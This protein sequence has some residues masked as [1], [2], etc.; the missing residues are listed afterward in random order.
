MNL[1]NLN[2]LPITDAHNGFFACCGSTSWAEGMTTAR[3]FSSTKHLIETA[4]RLWYKECTE[5]DWRAS[6]A[7]HPK[8]G[9][10]ASLQKRF[11]ATRHLAGVE[12]SG[13]LEADT[14]ILHALTQANNTYEQ[15]N[16][17]IF[18]V[19]ATGK[20]A[21]EMLMRLNERLTHETTEEVRIAMGEQHKITLIRLQKWLHAADWSV[22]KVSQ[23]TTHVLDTSLGETGKDIA[24]RLQER[25]ARG[26]WHTFAFGI[27]NH[28]GRVTDLLPPN[29]LL[30]PKTYRLVFDTG[31]YFTTRNL[32]TFYPEVEIQFNIWDASHYHV[33]LLL[34][35]FGYATYRG[36]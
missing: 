9:D 23:L 29:Y 20:R 26:H 17:F 36:S 34:N 6:F 8:I 25:N 7:H 18:I 24:I 16:G 19:C 14:D 31:H 27:T 35:P 11:A 28:D 15:A 4:T 33:P 21:D 2:Q 32:V 30:P 5:T 13:V 22:L 1:D 10:L 3:P 12:Q